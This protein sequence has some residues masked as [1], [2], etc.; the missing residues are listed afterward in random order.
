MDFE[1]ELQP[2]RNLV[3]GFALFGLC[4]FAIF[5]TPAHE[6]P[7]MHTFF[8]AG[9]VVVSG[10]L[11]LLLW[12]LGWRTSD[13]LTRLLAVAIGITA[14]FELFHVLTALEFSRDASEAM[15]L[16][17]LLRPVTWPP[18]AY[19]LPIS[20]GAAYALRNSARTV[21]PALGIGLTI[22]GVGLLF[23][24]DSI[25]P[26]TDPGWLGI[27]RPSLVLVPVLAFAVGIAYW[28][29]RGTQR[30]GRIIALFS[31]L[32]VVS[33]V[34]MLYSQAPADAAAMIAHAARFANGLFLLFTLTQMGT[35]DTSRRMRAEQE[36]TRLNEALED[37]VRARTGDLQAANSALRAEAATREL[38]ERRTLEQLSRLRLLHQT[39]HAIAERE[40]LASIFQ[41]VAGSLEDQLN[42]DF[43]CL[44]QYDQVERELT[45]ARVGTRSA[46]LATGIGL[47]EKAKIEIDEQGLGNCIRGTSLYERDIAAVQYSFAQRLA[48]GGLRSFVAVPL[49]VEQRSGVFGVLLVAR[50]SVDGFS[51][52]DRDFLE[53]LGE[54][55]AL[56]SNQ[57]QLNAALQNAYE[58]LRDTQHAVLQQ[59]R[60]RALG[61]MASGIAHD[62]NN[63]ISPASLYVES[64]LARAPGLDD[65]TRSQLETVQRA[66]GDV[67]QTVSRMGEF[68]R[69]RETKAI[70]VPVNVNV[71]L[72]QMPDLTRARWSDLAQARGA[73][74]EMVV[75]EAPGAPTILANES[76]LREALINLIFNAADALPGGG[77]ITLRAR[78]S[79][80]DGSGESRSVI[81]EVSD[82][83][84]GM[85]ENTRSHC[86]EP[87]FT[88]KG[89]R[90]TGLGLAMVYGIAQRHRAELQIDS[91]VG[92]GSTIRVRFPDATGTAAAQKRESPRAAKALRLLLIDD[93]PMILQSLRNALE[94]EGH[95]VTCAHGGQAGI[96]M[97]RAASERQQPFSAV[98]TDLGMPHVDG[99]QVAMAIKEIERTARVIML[100]GWGQLL[101]DGADAP[102]H[103]DKILSKPP[104]MWE[105]R[106]ALS[107]T[108][109][110][111]ES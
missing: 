52:S 14:A 86:L 5:V 73:A 84:V 53:Q 12:D 37:R 69:Q 82:D 58:E 13:A 24:F 67:A 76:E 42:V 29:V 36:L 103:V 30:L 20:L 59:E 2:V 110:P 79:G 72:S 78:Q 7:F 106:E 65:R 11:A 81:I 80:G 25:P 91:Q 102:A 104:N 41:V 105:L 38:A 92:K 15:R 62:I 18:A 48:R 63:A 31:I 50:N 100:T 26:Y 6:A 108:A 49:V 16:P 39:T 1:R 77:K 56:A 74:I 57:A 71:V 46:M 21:L 40:D 27:T 8:D 22:F 66:I 4:A 83:G 68:Y 96:D 43:A 109:E 95:Q 88:T 33:N 99:R 54:N 94:Y 44:C 111:Q 51:A 34:A 3:Y 47:G 75:E 55:V 9:I 70:L 87:F 17:K 45:V 19:I 101:A 93:D 28:R 97:Y 107:N 90:G 85:D 60:L 64:I 98:I 32:A 61:Q 35:I 89:V 23:Y 10:V